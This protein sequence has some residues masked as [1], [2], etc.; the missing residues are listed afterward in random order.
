MIGARLDRLDA[1]QR[2]LLQDG[3]VLGQTFTTA[4]ISALREE[5]PSEYELRLRALIQLEILDIEDDPRS[6]E[7]GQYR[8]VQ[9]LIREV[10]YERLSRQDR[11]DKHLAA[12]AHFESRD[13]PELAGVV[14]G[15]VMGAYNSSPEGPDREALAARALAGLTDAAQRAGTLGSHRQAEDL[16][17]QAIALST[18]PD[19][20]AEFQLRAA[21]MA[22][23]QSEVARSIDYVEAADAHYAATGN[24]QG[25]RKAATTHSWI[26]N[27]NYRSDEAL[28]VIKPV[29]DDLEDVDD[30][31]SIGVAA[32]AAR[33]LALNFDLEAVT[34]VDRLLPGAAALGLNEIIL[35]SLVTQATSLAVARRLIEAKAVLL[36]AAQVA[37][38]LGFLATAGRAYNNLGA[39]LYIDSPRE[40]VKHSSR[41]GDLARRLGDH[42]WTIRA[43]RDSSSSATRDGRFDEALAAL[44]EFEADQLSDFWK[45]SFEADRAF[46]SLF[47]GDDPDAV[48]RAL[49]AIA[50]FDSVADPQLRAGMDQYRCHVLQFAGRWDEAFDLAMGIDRST[51]GAGLY[52][53][54]QIAAWTERRDWVEQVQAAEEE[55]EYRGRLADGTRLLIHAVG[56]GLDGDRARAAELFDELIDLFEPIVLGYDL[57]MVRA[58]YAKTVG[59]DH[60]AAARAARDAQAWISETGSL[61]V[62]RMWAEGLPAAARTEA[63]G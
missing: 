2:S 43:T 1:T 47:R 62:E 12:A 53:G 27:G 50:S 24:L 36:G 32:E 57:A 39:I 19:Q 42:G 35:E 44:D 7:R 14:A 33:S 45:A 13:D 48:D 55:V 11:R 63:A 29:Y 54:A 5:D 16:F 34:A 46:V 40:A 52:E 59:Q 51:T 21:R 3:A 30:E 18:D 28:P 23:A 38:E 20:R 31:V 41:V 26:L 6:P 10:A 8:F 37:E 25:R 61:G 17:N 4:A 22:E 15:H 58:V 9:S 60:P 56:A 49:A